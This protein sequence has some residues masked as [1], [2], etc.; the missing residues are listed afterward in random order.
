MTW[1]QKVSKLIGILHRYGATEGQRR[2][3]A[4]YDLNDDGVINAADAAIVLNTPTCK[5]G[6]KGHHGH[7]DDA[8]GGRD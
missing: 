5:G 2:Y 8:R 1:G 6:P 7:D 3:K 4:K